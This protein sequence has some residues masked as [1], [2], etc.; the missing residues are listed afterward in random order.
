LLH[1]QVTIDLD[2]GHQKRLRAISFRYAETASAPPAIE[3]PELRK[4]IPL[5]EGEVYSRDQFQVGMEAVA[6]AYFARGFVEMTWNS[7]MQIDQADQTIAI[8]VDVNEGQQYTWGNIRMIGSTPKV[9]ALLKT[10]LRSGSPANPKAI[11]DFYREHSSALP[12][13]AS[14][15][16]VKWQYDREKA[17]VDL[18]FDLRTSG[19]T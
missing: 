3:P 15:K 6:R 13:G 4:L 19:A 8:I 12:V 10:K 11:E 16:T 1:V 17:T 5:S 18:T 9:E 2:E 14:P 7:E